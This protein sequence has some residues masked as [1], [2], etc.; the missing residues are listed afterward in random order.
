MRGI[1]KT[2]ASMKSESHKQLS[3]LDEKINRMEKY[4]DNK[5][6]EKMGH[7]EETIE[8][9]LKRRFK[10]ERTTMVKEVEQVVTKNLGAKLSTLE[11]N[12]GKIQIHHDV[13]EAVVLAVQE[14]AV[15]TEEALADK[16]KV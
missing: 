8:K 3:Q 15:R 2:L 10:Q 14:R 16:I 1:T 13:Q 4:L 7:P 11:K 6:E 5:M 12:M 9:Q